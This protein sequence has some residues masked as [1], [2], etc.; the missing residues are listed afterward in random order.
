MK[1]AYLALVA[2]LIASPVL[3]QDAPKPTTPPLTAD[4][5]RLQAGAMLDECQAQG[6]GV[7]N[8]A[9]QLAAQLAQAN[10]QIKDLQGQLDA[11]KKPVA[12]PE[13]GAAH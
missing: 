10:A 12:A 5:V 8:R 3:A 1:L 9:M 2:S 6:S 11:A 13:P 4:Q 7:Q